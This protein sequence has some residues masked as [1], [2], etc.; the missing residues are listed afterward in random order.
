MH[1]EGGCAVIVPHSRAIGLTSLN[2]T[3]GEKRLHQN[4]EREGQETFAPK[5]MKNLQKTSKTIE[6]EE[7]DKDLSKNHL[8][9][10]N[11]QFTK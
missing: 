7:D 8:S 9:S 6:I 3:G 2:T 11:Q 4:G 5:A 1:H 10:K